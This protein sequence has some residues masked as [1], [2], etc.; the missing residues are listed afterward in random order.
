M[1]SPSEWTGNPRVGAV[2]NWLVRYNPFIITVAAIALI[3][4]LLPGRGQNTNTAETSGI[5][6]PT[7]QTASTEA[8]AG[9]GTVAAAAK[10]A[11]NA[12]AS[13]AATQ[14]QANPNVL[15]FQQAVKRGVKLEAHCDTRT[16]RIAMPSWTA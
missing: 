10:A 5:T 12:A 1:K 14:V 13:V 2:R 15:T 3:A 7:E 8:A 6:S 16:G 4:L 11:P 9:A